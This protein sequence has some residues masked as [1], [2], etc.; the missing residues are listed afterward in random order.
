[1]KTTVQTLR[2]IGISAHVDAGKTTLTER[3]LFYCGRIHRMGEVHDRAGKGA[4]MDT[5]SLEKAHGITI[6]SAA[7]QV[8]WR[9]HAITIIDTPG[10]ADF[11]V[12]VERALR[13]LDGAVF[14]FS[15]V[16]GVQAQSIAVDRQMRRHGVPRVAF[17]NKMDR[18]GADPDAVVASIHDKLGVEAV[19]VQIPIGSEA[20]FEGIVDLLSLQAVRFQGEWGEHPVRAEV[21]ESLVAT[22]AA[23]RERLIDVV[24]RHDECLLEVAL[25]GSMVP[26]TTL[27]DAIRRATLARRI[28]P[29]V[30]GSAFRNVGVQPVLDAVV[31]Y[32][33]DPSEVRNTALRGN[34][35]HQEEVELDPRPDAPACA[36]AFKLDESRFGALAY[37]RVYQGTLERGITLHSSGTGERLR[38]GRLLRLHADKPTPI[39]SAVAGE[40]VGLF[41]STVESGDTLCGTDPDTGHAAGL[42]VAS[43]DVP[44]PVVSRTVRP[45]DDADLET[46]GKAL[47]R[48]A[49]E[50]PSLRVDRDPESGLVLIAGT[51]VLQL[52]LYA[53]RLAEEHGVE[54]RLGAPQVAYR[55]TIAAEVAFEHLHRKQSGGGSGQYAGVAGTLRPSG[56]LEDSLQFVDK[57]RGGAIPRELIP[58]CERGF[59]D[60]L[61]TGPLVGAPVVGVEVELLDG[62]THSE[63]SSDLAFHLAARDAVRAAL[64]RAEPRLLEPVMRVEVEAPERCFGGVQGSLARRRGVI[65]GSA[66]GGGR[67]TVVAEVPLA[68]MFDYATDL[69][70]LTGGEGSHAMSMAGYREV[71]A[72]EAMEVVARVTA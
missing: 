54:V 29:V 36:F 10:H 3:I 38:V 5:S 60:A 6:K 71:P 70:S 53:E 51:G 16:E 4:T 48:F 25:E 68:E 39:E 55:E 23:A 65:V 14:V 45:A 35:A 59:R 69:G 47:A 22:A 72:K 24:S 56:D 41:G 15:A 63:D 43:F 44:P 26:E 31:D 17:I 57:I 37:V 33:P 58:A 34:G 20:G 19:P 30:L 52:E 11:T 32:L 46:V 40:I 27:R 8:A 61:E 7:T 2:N 28:M 12:E 13:V 66:V 1:M 9:E 62:K 50:D 42:Q 18:T 21:P 67:V 49:R 64:R